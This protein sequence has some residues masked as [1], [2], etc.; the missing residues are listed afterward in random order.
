MNEYKRVILV[1]LQYNSFSFPLQD[2][3][4]MEYIVLETYDEF[5]NQGFVQAIGNEYI[6]VRKNTVK[7]FRLSE[8]T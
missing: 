5:I 4:D 6:L 3:M 2:F 1:S 8:A 7:R